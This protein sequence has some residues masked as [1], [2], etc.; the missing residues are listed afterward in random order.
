M[1][2][3]IRKHG[4]KSPHR[5]T[6]EW[7]KNRYHSCVPLKQK[8]LLTRRE[9][10]EKSFINGEIGTETWSIFYENN[11]SLRSI[12]SLHSSLI[13]CLD[14]NHVIYTPSNELGVFDPW[15][16]DQ[17]YLPFNEMKIYFDILVCMKRLN[18]SV[19]LVFAS[20]NNYKYWSKCLNSSVSCQ[21][22][23]SKRSTPIRT[24]KENERGYSN[25]KEGYFKISS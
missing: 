10:S 7:T 16:Q 3:I 23:V 2:Y 4:A 22:V 6:W 13:T 1:N 20:M 18:A 12:L 5:L 9:K 11:I 15:F 19:N 8:I 24:S 14:V 17:K 25:I 21:T